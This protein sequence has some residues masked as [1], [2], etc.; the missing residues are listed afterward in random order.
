MPHDQ[1]RAELS[2]LPGMDCEAVNSYVSVVLP[3][4]DSFSHDTWA[5]FVGG[6]PADAVRALVDGPEG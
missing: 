3:Q 1:A 6:L 4:T 5:A 2:K